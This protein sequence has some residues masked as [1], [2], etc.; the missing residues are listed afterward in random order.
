MA[1]ASSRSSWKGRGSSENQQ[2]A[3]R[4][5]SNAEKAKRVRV[6][7]RPANKAM[8]QEVARVVQ[9]VQGIQD[10][11]SEKKAEED[12]KVRDQEIKDRMLSNEEW[13]DSM[14]VGKVMGLLGLESELFHMVLAP[15]GK[16]YQE[17]VPEIIQHAIGIGCPQSLT[18]DT[19]VSYTLSRLNIPDVPH[20]EA[21]VLLESVGFPSLDGE[22][23]EQDQRVP[24]QSV[25]KLPRGRFCVLNFS[26]VLEDFSFLRELS[27]R[28][29]RV[30]RVCLSYESLCHASS[31]RLWE[32]GVF[33]VCLQRVINFRASNTDVNWVG[34]DLAN[35]GYFS[36]VVFTALLMLPH[37][38]IL[39]TPGPVDMGE[40][41]I[42][43]AIYRSLAKD[44]ITYPGVS[45]KGYDC[46]YH[47]IFPPDK[48]PQD[49]LSSTSGF[50]SAKASQ[51]KD[52]LRAWQHC[53]LSPVHIKDLLPCFPNPHSRT[54]KSLGAMK[55]LCVKRM[56]PTPAMALRIEQTCQSLLGQVKNT[57]QYSDAEILLKAEKQCRLHGFKPD[58]AAQYMLG[59]E[60]ALGYGE[61]DNVQFA[62]GRESERYT[63]LNKAFVKSETYS[64][65]KIK[66]PR[67]IVAPEM[68]E[69]GYGFALLYEAQK[70]VF[71]SLSGHVVKGMN[72]EDI[73]SAIARADADA[74]HWGETDFTSM[75]SQNQSV[76]MTNS[77]RVLAKAAPSRLERRIRE[78]FDARVGRQVHVLGPGLTFSLQTCLRSGSPDTS[79]T[80]LISNLCFSF[81]TLG[82]YFGWG[83][84]EQLSCLAT[85]PRPYFFEGDDGLLCFGEE[86]DEERMNRCLK[87]CGVIMKFDQDYHCDQLNFCGNTLV[88]L[89][90]IV[91]DGVNIHEACERM[92]DPLETLSRLCSLFQPDKGSAKDNFKLF[93][94]KVRSCACT[95]RSMPI[96]TPFCEAILKRYQDLNFAL[97][98]ELEGAVAEWEEAKPKLKGIST[99]VRNLVG[100]VSYDESKLKRLLN[101]EWG[102]SPI[103]GPARE[104]VEHL[105]HIPVGTQVRIERELVA[106]VEKLGKNGGVLVCE[107]ISD[108]WNHRL[109]VKRMVQRTTVDARA[110]AASTAASVTRS[111]IGKTTLAKCDQ[112]VRL[113]RSGYSQALLFV[114]ALVSGLGVCGFTTT[115]LSFF[116]GPA[117]MLTSVPWW[118]SFLGLGNAVLILFLKIALLLAACLITGFLVACV[119]WAFTGNFRQS[120]RWVLRGFVIY[121]VVLSLT[122]IYI[123]Y[124]NARKLRKA[125]SPLKRWWEAHFCAPRGFFGA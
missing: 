44:G 45:V 122:T 98:K 105:F 23:R 70:N 25:S 89:G 14:T 62:E 17:F 124:S 9:E 29:R 99:A 116:I 110:Y 35:S 13:K 95:Y 53:V 31:R 92:K 76:Q 82:Q 12:E 47:D 10:S 52:T 1:A 34:R 79:V 97:S 75:E 101:T 68:F 8:F 86:V 67:Y 2:A 83:E 108:L 48:T 26:V 109:A 38:L 103:A 123:M 54:N 19:R 81:A 91:H 77:G 118:A 43:A 104:A 58:D 56:Q 16:A 42:K 59:A 55:R 60:V 37:Q 7:G 96:V 100:Q 73:T 121:W 74:T 5:K 93:L 85:Y 28:E 120:L 46:H 114:A 32:S 6:G 57:I 15:P 4:R 18:V 69:R 87:E 36:D 30:V 51:V 50:V 39:S 94:A 78:Y 27:S 106:Q 63:Y 66:A 102:T 117:S 88:R 65:D 72:A 21:H 41:E 49:L 80:N 71:A 22:G 64:S 115:L 111:S 20:T 90:Q 84:S 125:T 11:S 112:A 3:S 119:C 107:T 113:L 40:K 61:I 24:Q 33:D